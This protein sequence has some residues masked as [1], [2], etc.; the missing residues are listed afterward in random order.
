MNAPT[1]NNEWIRNIFSVSGLKTLVYKLAIL[2]GRACVEQT[3]HNIQVE[4]TFKLKGFLNFGY[5]IG[6]P[7][8]IQHAF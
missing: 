2:R 4:I 7:T 3:G 5:C 1:I 8:T 6:L